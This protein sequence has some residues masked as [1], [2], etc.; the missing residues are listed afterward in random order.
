MSLDSIRATMLA[1]DPLR[2]IR[3]P[4][5]ESCLAWEA[6][7]LLAA[8]RR[9]DRIGRTAKTTTSK[10]TRTMSKNVNEPAADTTVRDT[11]GP[12]IRTSS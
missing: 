5:R 2:A 10:G 1:T 3:G 11:T 4:R 9:R 8:E 12:V 7:A 6:D